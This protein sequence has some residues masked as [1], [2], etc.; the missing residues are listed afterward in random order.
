MDACDYCRGF[1]GVEW[2]EEAGDICKHCLKDRNDS[3]AREADEREQAEQE[4]R[5]AR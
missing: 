3:K 5:W 1:D 2:D 4:E